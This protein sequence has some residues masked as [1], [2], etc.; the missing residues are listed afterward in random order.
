MNRPYL[1]MIRMPLQGRPDFGE[2]SRAAGRPY[3]ASRH[4]P[5]HGLP[6]LPRID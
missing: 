2:L 6:Q 5:E 4:T 3:T 1:P